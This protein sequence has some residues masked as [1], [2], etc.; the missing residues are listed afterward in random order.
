[1]HEFVLHIIPYPH[2]IYR[3]NICTDLLVGMFCVISYMH[4]I[5]LPAG[6]VDLHLSVP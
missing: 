5:V 6:S 4:V 2:I 1:M 3:T